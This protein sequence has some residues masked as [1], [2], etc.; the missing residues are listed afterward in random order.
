LSSVTFAECL[1]LGK[2]VFA[3][4]IS[5]PSVPHSVNQLVTESRTLPNAALG[6]DFLPSAREKALGKG[7]DSGSDAC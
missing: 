4:S 7:P 2:Y 1:P 6:K 3:E 5:V